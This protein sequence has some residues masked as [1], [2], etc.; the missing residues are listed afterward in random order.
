MKQADKIAQERILAKIKLIRDSG[1]S[2]LNETKEDR[3]EAINKAKKD[4]KFMVQRYFPH[5]A[6][7]ETP[8]FHIEYAKM[9]LRDKKFRGFAE[10]GRGLAKSVVCNTLLPL[11][12]NDEK[13][14][15]VIIGSN[16][17]KAVQLLEDIR[18]EFENNPQIIADFGEQKKF[19]KWDEKLWQT[20]SGFIGQ[21][22]GH[23]QNCRG[24]RIGALRPTYINVDDIETKETI[25]NE[26]SQD[27][28]VK[29]IERSL[30]PTMDGPVRRFMQ[31][32][33]AFAPVMIQKKLQERHPKWKIHHIKAYDP[34]TY[35]PTWFQ[36]YDDNYYKEIEEDDILAAQSE[37]NQIPHFEGK[38]WKPEDIQWT[39]LPRIDHFETI[40]GHWDIAYAGTPKADYNAVRIWGLKE[41]QF[42]YITSFVKKTKMKAAV[43][44][45]ADFQKE[46]PEGVKILWRFESQFWNDA[47]KD[48]IETVE[49]ENNIDLRLT[50]VFVQKS[51]KISRII[52]TYS[53]YQNGR[54]WYNEK[55]KAHNDTIIGI[56][57]L[58]GI[59]PNYKGHDDA[60]DADEQCIDFLSKHIYTKKE[61]GKPMTGR[62][63]RKHVY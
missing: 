54:I 11:W 22:L 2:N 20:K 52:S 26:S 12:L 13:V 4:Y 38:Y 51:S 42:Y 30:I 29:W 62:V 43:Q 44:F 27:E 61:G 49:K 17:D 48:V 23:G 32:N 59:E 5:Y 39:K 40:V 41:K 46:L 10:W 6:T 25:K 36:K 45:M 57:Q 58:M 34:I 14:Y 60:P 19:G 47:V 56:S 31:S 50:Q 1:K 63:E 55:M 28:I 24:L 7:F 18:L 9:V 35:K 15:M 3:K 53:Y 21:A 37:Y 33:N 16:Q 8:D